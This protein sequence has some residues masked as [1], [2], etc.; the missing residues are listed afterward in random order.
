M[1][2]QMS[3]HLKIMLPTNYS[4]TIPTFIIYIY[5]YIYELSENSLLVTLFSNFLV[6]FMFLDFSF[7][8]MEFFFLNISLCCIFLICKSYHLTF[9]YTIRIIE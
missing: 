3:S 4:L 9:F 6:V 5:I 7:F 2:K 1:C 8:F